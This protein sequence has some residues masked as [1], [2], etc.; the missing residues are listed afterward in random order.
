[1]SFTPKKLS[2]F[3]VTDGVTTTDIVTILAINNPTN[4]QNTILTMENFQKKFVTDIDASEFRLTNLG[5]LEFSTTPPTAIAGSISYIQNIGG[6]FN[7]NVPFPQV[8]DF[9]VDNIPKLT[10]SSDFVA[11]ESNVTFDM[12][13][14]TATESGGIEFT[15][16]AISA[17]SG[18]VPYIQHQG[19]R[20]TYNVPSTTNHNFAVNDSGKLFINSDLVGLGTG[21]TFDMN[22]VQATE[23][24]GIEFTNDP[25]PVIPGSVAYIQNQTN[26]MRLNSILNGTVAFSIS[27]DNKLTVSSDF[28]ALESNVTFDM[29]NNTATESGGM[30]FSTDPSIPVIS[31]SVPYIQYQTDELQLNSPSDGILVFSI[32]DLSKLVITTDF[33]A[34]LPNVTLDME[35]NDITDVVGIRFG[36][37]PSTPSLPETE[38]YFQFSVTPTTDRML[39]NV[40]TD[41]EHSFTIGGAQ[42]FF[43]TSDFVALDS[44]VDFNINKN[45]ITELGGIIFSQDAGVL[46]ISGNVPFIQY[47]SDV[48]KLNSPS[49]GRVA[50]SISDLDI[51]IVTTDFV[52]LESNVTFDMNN[53]T[54]TES[55]GIEFTQDAISALSENV[56]FIQY[57]NDILRLNS[58]SD[59]SLA[60]SI[61]DDNKLTVTS[62]FVALESNVT[63]DMN[64]NTATESGGME[65]SQ[66]VNPVISGTVPYIQFQVPLIGFPELVYNIPPVSFHVFRINNAIKFEIANTSIICGSNVDLDMAGNQIQEATSLEFQSTS[67]TPSLSSNLPYIQFSVA[68]TDR[69]L[70]NVRAN[71]SHSFTIANVQK[72]LLD[73]DE[74]VFQPNFSLVMNE[75]RISD[76]SFA[77]FTG[78]VGAPPTNVSDAS[79]F[80]QSDSVDNIIKLFSKQGDGTIVGPFQGPFTPASLTIT[81]V[82]LKDFESPI[83]QFVNILGNTDGPVNVTLS[84]RTVPAGTV[85]YFK[86]TNGNAGAHKINI[87]PTVDTSL[88][89]LFQTIEIVQDNDVLGM[90]Y[91]GLTKG[92]QTI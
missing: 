61:S 80:S 52:A 91:M 7:Y 42:K 12:N 86:D 13:N 54:A 49:D 8:H 62:D 38:P 37:I 70:Y 40:P 60:F 43:I 16:D 4:T 78:E 84:D 31:G 65:F 5:G 81:D 32:S 66:I 29:N 28:V 59:G 85:F 26:V 18:S 67:S 23:C 21:I 2:Q 10:V 44:G 92:Y 39:Y 47:E 71:Q 48:L 89:S 72:L 9:R 64:N 45:I 30:E 90:V 83:Q 14:N 11:L 77:A 24:G 56:P 51:L 34:L 53:N 19:G 25:V 15:Q 22:A 41:Q 20:T 75:N 1:M 82:L 50:L 17:I 68:A 46:P 88:N 6:Q 36:S 79:L 58:P 74:M 35:K 27:D 63:F 76:I 3:N 57:Q 87:I 33:V 69:M 73:S 55:G